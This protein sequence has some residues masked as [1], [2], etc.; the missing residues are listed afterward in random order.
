MRS[1]PV[2][3]RSVVRELIKSELEEGRLVALEG[4]TSA[5]KDVQVT[6]G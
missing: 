2:E 5:S 4:W 3:G 6:V 1:G